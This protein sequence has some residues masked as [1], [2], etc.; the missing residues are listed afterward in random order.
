MNTWSRFRV[1]A[2][3]RKGRNLTFFG[4]L[5]FVVIALVAILLILPSAAITL[6]VPAHSLTVT[7]TVHA[8]TAAQ[9]GPTEGRIPAKQL[10]SST[11]SQKLTIT[12]NGT[13]ALAAVPAT[14]QM[15]L[16]WLGEP[17]AYSDSYLSFIGTAAPNFTVACQGEGTTLAKN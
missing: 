11:F 5:G 3:S 1:W 12:P 16:C 6:G 8:T 15:E 13:H 17:V 7:A 2:S 9:S 10:Q 4:A 14:G